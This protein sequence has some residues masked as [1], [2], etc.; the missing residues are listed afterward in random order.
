MALRIILTAL[1]AVIMSIV[2]AAIRRAS[3]SL[4]LRGGIAAVAHARQECRQLLDR[5]VRVV[6]T[7]RLDIARLFGLAARVVT[8]R[9]RS[10]LIGLLII[11]RRRRGIGET[12]RVVAV[13]ILAVV[14][15]LAVAALAVGIL[16]VAVL[17]VAI[18]AVAMLICLSLY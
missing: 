6:V 3:L 13:A 16:T 9:R 7:R 1:L 15:V 2:L 5:I 12:R 18:L 10:I 17:T 14:V 11:G 4:I 8:I